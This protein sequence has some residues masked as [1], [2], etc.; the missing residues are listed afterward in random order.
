VPQ[1]T[2]RRPASRHCGDATPSS[3]H[4][5][6]HRRH[7]WFG[8]RA[9]SQPPPPVRQPARL[10]PA[11]RSPSARPC[12]TSSRRQSPTPSPTPVDRPA[13]RVR[14]DRGLPVASSPHRAPPTMGSSPRRHRWAAADVA[15]RLVI[16]VPGA[17]SAGPHRP[18]CRARATHRSI[19]LVGW[20]TV[21]TGGA[22]IAL[23]RV[24]RC[25]CRSP[26]LPGTATPATADPDGAQPGA[27]PV[28]RGGS[29]SRVARLTR[30][31]P[32]P[33]NVPARSAHRAARPGARASLTATRK[34]FTLD[35]HRS[36]PVACL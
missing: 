32:M 30:S 2:L 22:L 26:S 17:P 3:R 21:L 6:H 9:A 4:Q 18:T 8:T 27:T 20:L 28:R 10:R 29:L 7:L 5:R 31:A 11:L 12:W 35:F 13:A 25:A 33:S 19:V 24:L 34:P 15:R 23:R 14:R 16:G 1:S 36:Q